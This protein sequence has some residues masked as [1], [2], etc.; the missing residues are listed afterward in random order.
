ME[1]IK[2]NSKINF[3]LTIASTGYVFWSIKQHLYEIQYSEIIVLHKAPK[4][5]LHGSFSNF[6]SL[7]TINQKDLYLIGGLL[8]LILKYLLLLIY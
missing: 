2:W 6:L 3:G 7:N 4:S 5:L 8:S 1:P